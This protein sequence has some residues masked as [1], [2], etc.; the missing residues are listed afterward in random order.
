MWRKA[1]ATLLAIPMLF[2]SA[3]PAHAS[4]DTTYQKGVSAT[5][6]SSYTAS[7]SGTGV[8]FRWVADGEK[9]YVKDTSADGRRSGVLWGVTHGSTSDWGLCYNTLG[10]G[11]T[12]LCDLSFA[13][14]LTIWLQPVTC[15]ADVAPHGCMAD[16][17]WTYYNQV[18][19][20]T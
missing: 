14:N 11:K 17:D 3:A 10:S 12:A 4:Y 7:G 19:S 15:D 9:L 5:F 2:F 8:S 18:T 13:E 1:G 6:P 16:E 20:H